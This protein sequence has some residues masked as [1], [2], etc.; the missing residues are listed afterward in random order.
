MRRSLAFALSLFCCTSFASE[1]PENTLDAGKVTAQGKPVTLLGQGL[2]VGADAPNFKVVDDSFT[3]ITLEN[4]QGQAVLIS[5]VP[6]LDTGICSL[7]TKHF[8]EKVAQQ[9]PGVAMLTISADLPF[10]QKRFC[11]AENIDKVTT[12]SDSV[13]RDF[14][15]K[16]GLII[17]D[18]GLLTRAVF[19]LDKSHKVIYKQ[20]VSSLS[21][22]PEYDSVIEK[23]KTL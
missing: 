5:V 13:W 2:K 18:M 6:S 7:Q 9:F 16:Y 11:K 3:A 23:L 17:K 22:E 4:Y 12:L 10:A 14:G 20:L 1:L 21:T 19:I 8:N 15:Q